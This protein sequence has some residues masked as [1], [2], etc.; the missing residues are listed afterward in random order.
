MVGGVGGMF[1]W[2]E[3]L[4]SLEEGSSGCGKWIP[5]TLVDSSSQTQRNPAMHS[6]IAVSSSCEHTKPS[7]ACWVVK[8][9]GMGSGVVFSSTWTVDSVCEALDMEVEVRVNDRVE[10]RGWRT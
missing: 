6:W 7:G 10:E 2:S 1:S 4:S 9:G 8:R 5:V 3:S